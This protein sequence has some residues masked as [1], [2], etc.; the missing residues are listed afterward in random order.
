MYRDSIWLAGTHHAVTVSG[1][2]VHVA[3]V[4]G[5]TECDASVSC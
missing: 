4:P 2:R 5:Q 1:L 3:I